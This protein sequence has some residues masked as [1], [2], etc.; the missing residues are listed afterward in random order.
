VHLVDDDC[1]E[2]G[3][4]GARI[5]T[6]ADHHDLERLRRSHQHMGRR[7]AESLLAR[8][9]DVAVPLENLQPYH[10]RI[11]LEPRFLVV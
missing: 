2:S 5:G 1:Q 11:G 10:P 3:K 9:G 4:Q 8:V 6:L 7:L